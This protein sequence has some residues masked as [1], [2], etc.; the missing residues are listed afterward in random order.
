MLFQV[1]LFYKYRLQISRSILIKLVF[2]ISE[3]FSKAFVLLDK[4]TRE[5]LVSIYQLFSK[6]T[7][8]K[9]FTHVVPL[10]AFPSLHEH[11]SP[12]KI[13]GFGHTNLSFST[14]L[15]S[16]LFQHKPY[17]YGR[18]NCFFLFTM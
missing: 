9:M 2:K 12:S 11:P 1:Q 18:W 4:S 13:N 7:E 10:I 5:L 17:S 8:D 14:S 6:L 15:N 16:K 3:I